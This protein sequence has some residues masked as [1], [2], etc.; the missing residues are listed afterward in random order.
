M[1]NMV[2]ECLGALT[3]MHSQSLVPILQSMAASSSASTGAAEGAALT[4]WTIVASLRFCM[5]AHHPV[6]GP[7]F[8]VLGQTLTQF[9]PLMTSHA[10]LEVPAAPH[11][12]H[13]FTIMLLMFFREMREGKL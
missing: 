13:I 7:A 5:S 6:D 2:A 10:D 1:R 8:A 3:A 11:I 9:L 12:A 4:L